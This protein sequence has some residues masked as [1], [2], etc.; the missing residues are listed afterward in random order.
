MQSNLATTNASD[1]YTSSSSNIGRVELYYGNCHSNRSQV[2]VSSSEPAFTSV[3]TSTLSS[4]SCTINEGGVDW[5]YYY[6]NSKPEDL[7]FAIAHDPSNLGNNSFTAQVEVAVTNDPTNSSNFVD[8]IYKAE[9]VFDQTAYFALG[10]YWN[11]T[12]LGTLTDPVNIRFY[13]NQSEIDAMLDAAASWKAANTNNPYVITI[14]DIEWFKTNGGIYAPTLN[15]TDTAILNSSDLTLNSQV[16]STTTGVKYVEISGITGFSGGS[17]AVKLQGLN[18]SLPITLLNFNGEKEANKHILSW[19]TSSEENSDH[20]LI[21]HSTDGVSFETIG[22]VKAKG[23]SNVLQHYGFTN[24]TPSSSANYYKL[25]MVDTDGSYEYSKIIV[26][27]EKNN[28]NYM[29]YPNPVR[30]RIVY[31]FENTS[32][33]NVSIQIHDVLGKTLLSKTRKVDK[34]INQIYISVADLS[35]GSYVMTISHSDGTTRKNTFIKIE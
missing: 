2:S 23:Q 34:G 19:Q 11:V 17:A 7:I 5:T 4:G 29:F 31:N 16:D 24:A 6:D 35:E 18:N 15:V 1:V 32:D 33:N 22:Q 30:D 28:N 12:T 13:Y 8:G 3:G 26:L 20:F 25:K 27:N 21:M 14:G 10:R 9:N